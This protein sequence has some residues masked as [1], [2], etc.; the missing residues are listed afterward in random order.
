MTGAMTC[1]GASSQP[2]AVDSGPKRAAT[3]RDTRITICV[4]CAARRAGQE[5][6]GEACDHVRHVVAWGVG[7][8]RGVRRWLGLAGRWYAGQVIDDRAVLACAKSGDA[9]LRGGR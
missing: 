7:V 3:M 6:S 9:R 1:R 5:Q 2:A 4:S 8:A